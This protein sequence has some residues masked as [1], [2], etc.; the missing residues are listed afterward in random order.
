MKNI[1]HLLRQSLCL[2]HFKHLH[3][4]EQRI[5]TEEIIGLI[6]ALKKQISDQLQHTR[7]VQMILGEMNS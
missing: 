4:S 7:I 6:N 1:L 2:N 5:M 3:R